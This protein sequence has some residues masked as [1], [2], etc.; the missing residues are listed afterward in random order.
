MRTKQ[1]EHKLIETFDQTTAAIKTEARP[2]FAELLKATEEYQKSLATSAFC[3]NKLIDLMR[4][5][6]EISPDPEMNKGLDSICL[7]IY[8]YLQ[9]KLSGTIYIFIYL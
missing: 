2:V 6:V 3:G 5:V 8:K 1:E 9:P 4:R 7:V